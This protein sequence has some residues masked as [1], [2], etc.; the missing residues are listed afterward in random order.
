MSTDGPSQIEDPNTADLPPEAFEVPEGGSLTTSQL[1]A[2]IRAKREGA[3]QDAGLIESPHHAEDIEPIVTDGDEE[4]ELPEPEGEEDAEEYGEDDADSDEQEGQDEEPTEAF[5]VG[6]YK[7]K[8]AAEEGFA[9]K[10]RTIDRLFKELHERQAYQPQVEQ[11]PQQPQFDAN[12]WN[13][14]AEQAVAQGQGVTGAMAA[15]ENGGAAGFDIYLAHWMNDPDQ[16]GQALAFNNEVQRQ[17]AARHAVAAVQPLVEQQ[18]QQAALGEADMARQTA[19]NT[20]EDFAEYEDEIH[21]IASGENDVLPAETRQCLTGLAQQGG[22]EG[23]AFVW[24]YLYLTAKATTAESRARAQREER[25]QRRASADQRKLAAT[26]SSAEG[27]SVRTPP[28]TEA[29]SRV[30]QKRNAIR[31]RL[32][33]PLLPTE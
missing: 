11:Q 10:D 32:G 33:Q 22:A 2:R 14:W 25:K 12:E 27:A 13:E 31:K 7:T 21:R 1:E 8:E 17:Y 5:Y 28:M 19:Q 26:V 18:R 9:E 20:R 16:R 6:R 4:E 30:I 29:E 24:D 15:L 3:W 23:K